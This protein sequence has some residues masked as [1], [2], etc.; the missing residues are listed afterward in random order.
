V[1]PERPC[2][3]GFLDLL[4]VQI[5]VDGG[6]EQVYALKDP[7]RLAEGNLFLPP[8]GLALASLLDGTRTIAEVQ[9]EFRARYGVQPPLTEVQQ[10]LAG[11]QEAYLLEGPHLQ[12]FVESFASASVRPAAC[13]GNYPGEPR[14]LA[15][16][17]DAQFTREGGPGGKPGEGAPLAAG[18]VRGLISPHID[19]HRG[20]HSY[21]WAWRAIAEACQ[22]EVFVIFGTSHAGTGSILRP[23]D[24]QSPIYAL[25]RKTF[26]TPLGELPVETELLDRLLAAYQGSPE[27]ELFAGEF[28]H[29][30]EHSIEFQAVYLAHLFARRRPVRILPVLCGNIQH[31][32]GAPRD[33]PRFA[34]FHDALREA[35]EPIPREK[36]TF[37]AG[38]DLAHVGAQFHEPPVDEQALRD[39]E[40]RD[41]ETLRLA[42][43]ERSA[44]AVHEDIR[45][46]GDPRNICGH[47]A[48]VAMLEALREEPLDGRLLHYDRWHD[49][50]SAVSFAAG[51]YT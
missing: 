14:E 9:G 34:R 28:H 31:L 48:L 2:L 7:F 16:F 23:L 50:V 42:L 47:S 39:V 10:L 45:R 4:P 26:Q 13:I 3:R 6:E 35:L 49:G 37:V 8:A 11:L 41:R 38:I 18:H 32:E 46:D 22:A 27:E 33:D 51:M 20:G 5:E 17:L 1:I 44:E 12:A 30:G 19:L 40:T 25:T 21:A 43:E 29:R 15:R 24:A 36:V